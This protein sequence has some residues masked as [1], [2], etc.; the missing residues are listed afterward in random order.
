M[1]VPWLLLGGTTTPL[2]VVFLCAISLAQHSQSAKIHTEVSI[3]V[4]GETLRLGM[5]K[6][7]VAEKLIGTQVKKVDDDQHRRPADS[8]RR[9]VLK[10][11][12]F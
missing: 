10:L 11:L 9:R 1:R 2:A 7:Q 6:S 8:A 5:T 3:E 12:D 4:A